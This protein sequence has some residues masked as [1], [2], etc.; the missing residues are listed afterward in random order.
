MREEKQPPYKR[1]EG[2]ECNKCKRFTDVFSQSTFLASSAFLSNTSTNF[3]GNQPSRPSRVRPFHPQ[4]SQ[5]PRH[6]DPACSAQPESGPGSTSTDEGRLQILVDGGLGDP[7]G[8][9]NAD[10]FQFAGVHQA[11]HGHL[12]HAH[13]QGHFGDGEKSDVA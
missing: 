2:N 8:A 3:R 12:R 13:D 1:K 9:S 4:A 6:R 10:R 7:E 5:I 11:I